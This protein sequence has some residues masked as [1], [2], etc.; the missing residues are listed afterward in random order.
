MSIDPAPPAPA[1]VPRRTALWKKIL[2]I[3]AVIVIAFVTIVML[4][5]KHYAVARE[6][7]MATTPDKPFQQVNDFHNWEKWSPWAKLD[8]AMKQ[9]Y[10]GSASGVGAIYT[11]SGNDEVGE[12]KMK[13]L[14]SKPNERVVIALEF[15]R[16][17]PSSSITEFT[18]QPEGAGTTVTW[19]MSGENNFMSKAFQLFMKMDSM[20]GPDFEKGLAAMKTIVE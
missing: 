13:I 7:T 8:P 15:L 17:F 6:R 14:E 11:W 4:Q 18:F 19:K 5:P 16:P 12:G 1:V 20:I 10:E 2:L 9:T 3:L